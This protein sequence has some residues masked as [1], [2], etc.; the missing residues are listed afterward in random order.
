MKTKI[1]IN[2][3]T[4]WRTT[5]HPTLPRAIAPGDVFDAMIKD[6][7]ATW[8]DSNGTPQAIIPD[9]F[10]QVGTT[11][12]CDIVTLMGKGCQCGCMAAERQAT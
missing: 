7:C 9:F 6:G 1:R 2:E 5:L 3:H 10:T 12:T 8:T 4:D 11:C